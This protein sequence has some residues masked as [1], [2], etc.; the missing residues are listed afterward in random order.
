MTT[1]LYHVK[2]YSFFKYRYVTLDSMFWHKCHAS[3]QQEANLLSCGIFNA[4][5]P[6]WFHWPIVCKGLIS[7]CCNNFDKIHKSEKNVG[8]MEDK[9]SEITWQKYTI[10]APIEKEWVKPTNTPDQFRWDLT[11]TSPAVVKYYTVNIHPTHMNY[12]I[13][14]S[15]GFLC[16]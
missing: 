9:A 2:A 5:T 13:P 6:G 12:S 3:G 4:N 8:H 15:S 11:S 10:I 1:S 16:T 7:S 14:P